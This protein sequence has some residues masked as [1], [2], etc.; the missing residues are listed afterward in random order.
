MGKYVIKRICIMALQLIGV[1]VFVFF[2]LR[3]LPGDPAIIQAGPFATEEAIEITRR[4]MGLDKPLIEQFVVYAKGLMH[5]DLGKS[6][7]T[8][9]KVWDDL[10]TRFSA[11]MSLVIIATLGSVLI[12]IP[13]GILQAIY[14]NSLFDRI[15]NIYGLL[16]GSWPDFFVGLLL[17]YFFFYILGWAPPPDGKMSPLII[18]PRFITGSYLID[19][20][21]TGNYEAARSAASHLILPCTALIFSYC[22][23]IMKMMRTT[24]LDVLDSDF[25][26]YANLIGL[27]KKQ[28]RNYAI[29]NALSPVVSLIGIRIGVM[30]GGSVLIEQVFSLGGLGQYAVQSAQMSDYNALTGFLI[31]ACIIT[32]ISLL[33]VDLI[34]AALDPRIRY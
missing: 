29:R 12:A 27:P 32:L 8:G 5:G 2:I 25:I 15:A 3:L 21:L 28:V 13:I 20:L 16:A 26:R 7:V 31:V 23:V 30:I 11:T 4:E 10:R 6:Y 1:V 22:G 24:M 14:P 19:G 34:Q 9:N 17:I 33:L 18:P